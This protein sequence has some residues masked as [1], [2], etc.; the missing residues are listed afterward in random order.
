MPCNENDMEWSLKGCYVMQCIFVG[1]TVAVYRESAKI[2]C[3]V[4]NI[5]LS[6]VWQLSKKQIYFSVNGP[7]VPS[8]LGLICLCTLHKN[9]AL[10]D[11]FLFS[12]FKTLMPWKKSCTRQ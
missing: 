2:L 10:S 5:V 8:W 11:F 6:G 1:W 4:Q 12:F 9:F 7:F 3:R